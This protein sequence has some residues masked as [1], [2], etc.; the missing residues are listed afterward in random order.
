MLWFSKDDCFRINYIEKEPFLAKLKQTSFLDSQ[1]HE[2]KKYNQSRD[3]M[4]LL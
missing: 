2:N 3:T 1:I 4:P